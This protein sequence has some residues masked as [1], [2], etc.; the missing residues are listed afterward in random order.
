M[1]GHLRP[2]RAALLLATTALGLVGAAG[3]A[4]AQE[5]PKDAVALEEVVVTAQKRSENVQSIPVAVTAVTATGMLWTFSLRFWAVTTTSSSATASFGV[6]WA[7][8]APAAPTSPRAVV[9]S[10]SAARP[11]RRCPFIRSSLYRSPSDPCRAV[12][13]VVFTRADSAFPSPSR[14]GADL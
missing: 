3:A 7:R 11:G 8:A 5:T 10:S 6:S 1:K 14:P 13:V 9:A 2:G 12:A 4:L